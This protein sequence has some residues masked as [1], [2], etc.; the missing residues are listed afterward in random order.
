MQQLICKISLRYLKSQKSN[1]LPST[2]AAISFFSI[3]ISVATLIIVTAVQNGFRTELVKQIIGI[4]AH[5]SLSGR[6]NINDFNQII[7]KI[8]IELGDNIT[9][10]IPI[11]DS[12]GMLVNPKNSSSAGVF[13]KGIIADDIKIKAIN[14]KAFTAEIKN[15]KENAIILGSDLAYNLGVFIGDNVILIAPEINETL[16]GVMPRSKTYKVVGIANFGL[17]QYNDI[18]AFIPLNQAQKFFRYSN[19]SVNLIEIMIKNPEEVEI[20]MDR[21]D[22]I[23]SSNIYS[24][25]WKKQN[26]GL[27]S[28]LKME[29][30]VM[31]LILGMFVI[32][33]IFSIF[34]GLTMMINDKYKS[35]AI[36]RSMGF[37][38]W[39]IGEVFFLTGMIIIITGAFIG[40][41]IGVFLSLN[42]DKIKVWLESL[43]NVK[44]FDGAIYFVSTLPSDIKFEDVILIVIFVLF[45]GILASIIP[46]IKATKYQPAEALKYF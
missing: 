42:I 10:I 4:N 35:I 44:L 11:I 13:V 31:V 45:F 7:N 20:L 22:K 14:F 32:G 23:I 21:I 41:T 24:Y 26:E 25:S 37:K 36:L 3:V 9:Q 46:A 43:L 12:K 34:A 33:S 1:Y 17:S 38:R 40:T 2:I 27:L 15:F 19:Q 18:L 29:K 30:S 39:Q 5:I 8:K 6:D 16:F 28:A